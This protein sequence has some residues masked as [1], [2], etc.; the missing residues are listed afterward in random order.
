MK[1]GI[2]LI[3]DIDALGL[4]PGAVAFWWLGQ[5]SYVVKVGGL[6]LYFD[7][8][9]TPSARRRV[10]PLLRPEQIRHADYVFGSHDHGDH[11]DPLACA[12]IATAS[13]QAKFV[14]SHVSGRHVADLGIA[15]SRIIC[16]DA[17]ERYQARDL[18]VTPIAAAHEFFDHDAQLG[19]PHLGFVVQVGDVTLYFSG[20]TLCYDGL[21][22][23]LS[24]WDLD[25]AFVPINGRDGR[26]LRRNCF[27]NMTYQEA[28][29]LVGT[30]KPRLA[31]P[32]HYDMFEGNLGEPE[33]FAD[34]MDVKYPEVV[35]WIG[36][37]GEAVVLPPR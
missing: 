7:P 11:I 20:D 10:A 27:G 23:R 21:T 34:Y 16:L 37:H 1:T 6:I 2:D 5:L 35:Y 13:P 12:G 14:C 19:F 25:V 33:L 15:S 17:E 3:R 8:F 9:L 31:V 36:D 32:G 30:L 29:D 4:A 24:A 18:R 26:R 22:T 28:V